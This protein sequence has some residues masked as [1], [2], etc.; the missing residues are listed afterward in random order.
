MAPIRP[1]SLP[2]HLRDAA[3]NPKPWPWRAGPRTAAG[4]WA[5]IRASIPR[6]FLLNNLLVGIPALLGVYVPL[7]ATG[8][9]PV[10]VAAMP[11]LGVFVA[12]LAAALVIEDAAFYCTHRCG[13]A[14]RVS[15]W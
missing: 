10:A 12:Q 7:H 4:F 14:G 1:P 5:L 6:V 15:M 9:F 2:P 11:S 3:V 13:G 8:R